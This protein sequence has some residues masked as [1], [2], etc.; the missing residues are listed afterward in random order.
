MARNPA[1]GLLLGVALAGWALLAR[2]EAPGATT[3]AAAVLLALVGCALGATASRIHPALPGGAV[4][5][6]V[7][8]AVAMT[9][10]ASLSGAATA[11]PLG[12]GN[13]DAALFL[14]ATAGLLIS[15][16]HVDEPWRTGVVSAAVG[17]TVLCAL[18]ASIAGT[19]SCVLL[20]AWSGVRRSGRAITWQAVAAV[21]LV[22]SVGLT[23]LLGSGVIGPAPLLTATLSQERVQ[24]WSEAIALA[25]ANP[26]RGVGAGAFAL[27]SP[28]ALTDPDLAWAHSAPLQV[29]AELGYVGFGLLTLVVAWMVLALGRD[30]LL[31]A[32][33]FLPATIDYVLHFGWVVLV[34]SVVL[35]GA[36]AADS[37]GSGKPWLTP[38]PP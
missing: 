10:P 32:A 15:A 27:H 16:P 30:A 9:L 7:A 22:G 34:F 29:A 4:A 28:T 13:A 3:T 19:A 2:P 26:V 11:P 35:G 25:E 37:A 6:A 17:T 33:L 36:W 18:T 38:P 14:A 31:V 23:V 21:L 1:F 12:Y 5:V 20:L 24:L 8:A